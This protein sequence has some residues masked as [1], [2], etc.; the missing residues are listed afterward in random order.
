MNNDIEN[1]MDQYKGANEML[2]RYQPRVNL[3]KDDNVFTNS[4]TILKTNVTLKYTAAPLAY[5]SSA[6]DVTGR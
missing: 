4:L 1:T 3:V 2:K 6:F 5:G